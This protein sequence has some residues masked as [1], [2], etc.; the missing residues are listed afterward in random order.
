MIRS[1]R[2]IKRFSLSPEEHFNLESTNIEVERIPI[3]IG[4]R[5]NM[6]LEGRFNF[7]TP[8]VVEQNGKLHITGRV[9]D[10]EEGIEG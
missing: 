2:L 5:A 6:K 1:Y 10:D 7:V 4:K 8:V 9:D 3:N